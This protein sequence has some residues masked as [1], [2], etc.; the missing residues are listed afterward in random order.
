M[1][2]VRNLPQYLALLT[3][4]LVTTSALPASGQIDERTAA[5]AQP[6]PGDLS[7]V[8]PVQTNLGWFLPENSATTTLLYS[9]AHNSE[10]PYLY[11][12]D[13]TNAQTISGTLITISGGEVY[14][15]NGLATHPDTG[16]LWVILQTNTSDFRILAT[17]D[18][19][20]GIAT[21]IG[22]LGDAFA[23]LAFDTSGTL[24]GLTGVGASEPETLYSISTTNASTTLLS[25]VGNDMPG[26]ALAYNSQDE[27][28]YHASWD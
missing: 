3:V 27:L 8:V 4:L 18:P 21:E 22:D 25:F 1:I 20:T 7:P 13:P 6:N 5:V 2:Q 9:I 19:A 16:V 15:G 10:G 24:Y 11:Q 17:I 12:I 26:E 28:F 23:A 14:G